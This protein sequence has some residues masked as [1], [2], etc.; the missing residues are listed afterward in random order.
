MADPFGPAGSRMYRT[1]DLARWRADGVLEF[2]GRADAQVKL[3]GFRIEPGRD[4]GGAG[5]ACRGGAGGG[6]GARGYARATSG[7]WPMWWRRAGGSVGCA[8]RCGR[9]LAS[10]LPDYMVPSAFVVLDRLPLTPNGKLDREAL[11]APDVDAVAVRARRAR[12]RRRCCARCL[13][14]CWGC[15]RVGIDDNFFELG[16]HSL[17]ATR[18]VSRIRATLG[19]RD[20]DPRAVRSSDR[21]GAGQAACTR[22]EAARPA[23]RASRAS[24]RDPAVVCAAPAVVPRSSG[25]AERDL[26]HPDGAA[27]DGGARPRRAGGGARRWW[28]A[29]RACARSS[30]TRSA[31]RGR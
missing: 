13:P 16:G 28:R 21:G 29:T 3:R 6:D 25:R 4:R 20:A 15:E 10:S 22:R 27:A 19:C 24:G 1:G 12:R 18:L 5:A 9:I 23:L 14:R 8:R 2:L 7:W 30:P 26:H 11:P 31:C 17:L